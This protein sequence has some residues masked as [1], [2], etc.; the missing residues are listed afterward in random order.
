MHETVTFNSFEEFV[1]AACGHS[2]M[3]EENRVS[4]RRELSKRFSGTVDFAEALA[5]ARDGWPEGAAR[6]KQIATALSDRIQGSLNER[7]IA[8]WDVTGADVDVGRF[9]VG[10]PENMIDFVPDVVNAPAKFLR[11]VINISA[12]HAF[13]VDQ[14]TRKGA[15]VV[16]LVDALESQGYR[17]EIDAVECSASDRRPTHTHTTVI[18]LK[19]AGEPCEIDRLAFA[20]AHPAM[21]RRLHFSFVETLSA[22]WRARIHVGGNYGYP[23]NAATEAD[24][25]VGALK[26]WDESA[27]VRWV[28]EQLRAQG[29]EFSEAVNQ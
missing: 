10:E 12:S 1:T 26:L 20:M 4:R 19:Q 15:A 22:E 11:V 23:W 27:S 5:L 17:V 7:Q 24:I 21:L 2:D 29:I 28:L 3:P 16:A 9:V 18:R 13:T 8:A 6:V 14:I 25:T